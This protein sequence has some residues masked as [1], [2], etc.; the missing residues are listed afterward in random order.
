MLRS[1]WSLLFLA[2]IVSA[3]CGRTPSTPVEPP[4]PPNVI[5]VLVDT[6][7]ADHMSTYGYHRQTT[8]FIDKFA[9]RGVVFEH[10]RSQASCT[11]PSVNSL[12]T[13][14]YPGVFTLQEK[15]QLGIPEKYPAIAEI[16]KD[17][18][19]FTVAVSS[20]PIVRATA[21]KYNPNGGF[22]RGF[23]VFLEDCV[24]GHGDCV[25]RRIFSELETFET[26]FFLYA[27]YMEPHGFYQPP[28]KHKRRFA[29]EYDGFD[30]IKN[31]DPNPIGKMLYKNGPKIDFTDRDIQH[32]VDLY[33]EEILYFDV[34]FRRLI[35]RLRTHE[36]LDNTIV[37]LVSDHG[38]EF[39][40]HGHM[41]HCRGIWNTV[42][43]VPLVFKLPGVKGGRRIS[44][45]VQNID[46]V[47]TILD[48][49]GIT[50]ES[51]EPEGNSLRPL[52]EGGEPAQ[53]H[54]FAVQGRYRSVDDE[55]F[56]LILDAKDRTVTL[57]DFMNDPLEQ[58]DLYFADHPAAG[59]LTAALNR[60]LD[61]TGELTGL[62][63]ALAAAKAKEEE[64]RA[65]GY[66][67]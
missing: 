31:G 20:S 40:E 64:L 2:L 4:T 65:L 3:A 48:Y 42:T 16:L 14:R 32:L 26:P 37:V 55:N 29:L 13:S 49:L 9:S 52:I 63:E 23:D 30:F 36:L 54:A 8:P 38:E 5:I 25:N 44:A 28:K 35:R 61:Q 24:W 15:G 66:I 27:H 1:R 21:S 51:F 43:H 10:A 33:D 12:L 19:Y 67:Q 6:L 60:W 39:L 58:E 53:E 57:F 41:R 45:A 56:H 46:I 7:R 17:Q 22:D 59:P 62:D 11:F 34:V 47:P 18:G 50:S